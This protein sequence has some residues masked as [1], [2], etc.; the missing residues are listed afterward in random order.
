MHTIR[1]R[2]IVAK[3]TLL[4]MHR[5]LLA[6]C[7][8]AVAACDDPAPVGIDLVDEQSGTPYVL[9]VQ[10]SAPEYASAPEGTGN[11]AR[12]LFGT[13]DDPELGTTEARGYL[14]FVSPGVFTQAF[15]NN[16]IEKADLLLVSDYVYGD[17]L[18]E[19][20][21]TLRSVDLEWSGSGVNS[22]TTIFVG[23][24]VA[25]SLQHPQSTLLA[26][27][28]PDDWIARW[29]T[30]FKSQTFGD[31]FH[32]FELTTDS[33]SS[34]IGAQVLGS[35]IR[36]ITAGDTTFF[37]AG[38]SLTRFIDPVGPSARPGGLVFQ[39]GQQQAASFVPQ[40]GA[41]STL[42]LNRGLVRVPADTS[43]ST[44]TPT[45]F[46]RP[47][48]EQLQLDWISRDGTRLP[49]GLAS[50]GESYFQFESIQLHDSLS[51][52]LRGRSALDHFE[53]RVPNSDNGISVILMP[54]PPVL[55][56][57]VTPVQQ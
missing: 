23:D 36:V 38:R 43:L 29:D 39:D 25:Q 3:R 47:A 48:I 34:V 7:L 35:S 52:L 24:I 5:L 33:R 21:V 49:I 46:V 50:R 32:G 45:G 20:N 57:A 55:H 42:V 8:V 56:L 41:P 12:T 30:T 28:L 11:A 16:P 31:Q 14:D 4:Y 2:W 44:N 9:Q 26:I 15:E 22:D 1:V 19:I 53:L 54:T 27:P 40:F 10:S 37:S 17:S 18:S 13:V 6:I 51:V